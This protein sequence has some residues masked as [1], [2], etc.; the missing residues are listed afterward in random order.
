MAVIETWFDQ[1][2]Q[3]PVKVHYI[4]G[5]LFS[6]NGNGN[7]VG[8]HVFDNGEPV[9]LSGTV[10]GYVVTADGSTV[11]CTGSRSGNSASILIPAAAYQPGAVFI[12]VFLTDGSTVTT[13]ASV[14][15]NVLRARTNN[16]VSPGSVVTDWTNTIN[17]AMQSVVDANAANIAVEYDSLV[18][19]VPLGKY[20]IHDNLLYRCKTPIASTESWTSSHWVR[21]RLSDV[22]DVAEDNISAMA[23]FGDR[24]EVTVSLIDGIVATNGT[25]ETGSS[26]YKHADIPVT[27]GERYSVSGYKYSSSYPAVVYWGGSTVKSYD[28]TPSAGAF[29]DYEI[30]VPFDVDRMTVNTNSSTGAV[31][32]RIMPYKALIEEDISTIRD[33]QNLKDINGHV[34]YGYARVTG[35][36]P[37]T[38][39]VTKYNTI[40][41]GTG[42]YVSISVVPGEKYLLS[43]YKYGN[44]Y[45][46]FIYRKDGKIVSYDTTITNNT[47]FTN[48]PVTIPYGV[49]ELVVN[50]GGTN[51]SVVIFI[52]SIKDMSDAASVDAVKSVLPITYQ[53]VTFTPTGHV[54]D[55]GNTENPST[56]VHAAVSVNAGEKYVLSGYKYSN[57][58]PGYIFRSNGLVMQYENTLS[59]G[60]FKNVNVT[61]PDG[62]EELVVNGNTTTSIGIQKSALVDVARKDIVDSLLPTRAYLYD[63]V[64]LTY[65][66]GI[67]DKWAGTTPGA[68]YR[69]VIPVAE[70]EEYF[71]ITYKWGNDYPPYLFLKN[72]SIVSYGTSD[73]NGT[74]HDYY[75]T[76]PSGVDQ[77][78]V[79]S[80]TN[81]FCYVGKKRY[82]NT[83]PRSKWSNKKIA[84]FGTSIP[85]PSLYNPVIG[86][87]EYVADLLGATVYNEAVGSS[88]ARRGFKSKQ[89]DIDPYGWT[90]MGIAALWNMGSSLEEKNE[91]ITNWDSKWR[92]LTGYNQAMTDGIRNKAIACS[93]ENKLMK[94]ITDT[95]V[96]LYVFD[97]G[98]N[99]WGSNPV[100]LEVNTDNPFDMSTY[101]GAMNTY[102]KLILTANPRAKILI[103]SHYESQE[104][105]GLIEMQEWVARYWN[106]PFGE[107]YKRLGWAGDRTVVSTGYWRN[108][109]WVES[110]GSET[111]YTLKQI[112][113]PDGR[114]PNGDLS[115]HACMDI[116]HIVAEF[117]NQITPTDY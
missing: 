117:V 101:Q 9:T 103:L 82:V 46:A 62:V 19:P 92:S 41:T 86:Y 16:Q 8:V 113:I 5:N 69:S 17:A 77:M 79:N 73:R 72:G 40:N 45:P 75:A 100:D 43:G 30:T 61:I 90:G 15:T 2:L 52:G 89:S 63:S 21:V 29:S 14:A 115:G 93:Y 67:M 51:S 97:H 57:E 6:H 10:S 24:E 104:R 59:A 36:T 42:A 64:P 78:V 112:H 84:W 48:I 22:V 58:Y 18:F 110:G 87:A 35:V 38:G 76:V 47:R 71:I 1:D 11:P 83:M 23:T 106:L 3:K 109:F 27:G 60:A 111:T 94:Y 99:D 56:G 107:L 81:S 95:P 37:I 108:G 25:V 55:K 50:G 116:A 54:I 12:T 4:D 68:G 102:I 13:L 20:C 53:D 114:H 80:N 96:D 7:R 31:V 85:E 74:M 33:I 39:V 65:L 26:A 91:I 49:D 44:D 70:G 88:C 98:Y 32:A 34:P 105:P 66:D 28:N